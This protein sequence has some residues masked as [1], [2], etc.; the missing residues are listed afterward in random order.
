MGS[1]KVEKKAS[2]KSSNV[3]T[4]KPVHK[5]LTFNTYIHKTLKQVDPS[6]SIAGAT[7]LQLDVFMKIFSARLASV[8]IQIAHDAGR[9]TVNTQDV[10]VAA[11]LILPANL[12]EKAS[13]AGDN[14]LAAYESNEDTKNK[15]SRSG[16]SFPPHI[17]EKFLR[18][19]SA[20]AQSAAS[21]LSVAQMSP[22]YMAAVIECVA[23]CILATSIQ[24]ATE[25]KR[26]TINVRHLQLATRGDEDLDCLLNSL[27]VNWL[28]GGVMP[29]I[30]PSL[31]PDKNKQRKLAAKRR[32]ARKENGITPT[33]AAAR[34]ALP[35][36][37]AL[38]DIK[39]L[40]KTCG[41]LQRKEHFRRF[42]KAQA[43]D[44]WNGDDAVYFGA[45]VIEYLQAYIENCVTQVFRDSV[46]AMA[47]AGRETVEVRDI[48]FVWRFRKP[49]GVDYHTDSGSDNLADPGLH[50]LA[51]RG[52][53]KRIGQACYDVIR[54][55]M[56]FYTSR[57]LRSAF[58]LMERQKVKTITLHYL[59]RGANM[60]GVNIPIDNARRRVK[61]NAD[62][63][64]EEEVP[65]PDEEV[66]TSQSEDDDSE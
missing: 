9:H 55:I 12:W 31:V 46:E 27:N 50:R 43:E 51:N 14:A 3:G 52:G 20:A 60:V 47:H 10:Q 64:T 41:L 26:Q 1:T 48:E 44:Q 36:T 35:G 32:K 6:I 13:E 22:I 25:H 4:K 28:G 7:S 23:E 62:D 49:A 16:L 18:Q 63:G 21:K 37:K 15:A 38:R 19:Q 40:Q 8:A 54:D 66:D 5:P 24:V 2:V 17:S 58:L 61:K 42:I 45:G 65:L 29:Y 59:R 11:K 30:H 34:K 39:Q 56:A 33:P 57:V 53:V